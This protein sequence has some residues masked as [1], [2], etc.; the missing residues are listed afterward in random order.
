MNDDI[1]I[2]CINVDVYIDHALIDQLYKIQECTSHLFLENWTSIL[3]IYV[4]KL[5]NY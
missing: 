5:T 1:N 4:A 2:M 3:N